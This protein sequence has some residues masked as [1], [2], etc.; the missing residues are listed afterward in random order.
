MKEKYVEIK[1]SIKCDQILGANFVSII[2]RCDH[3][4]YRNLR[5]HGMTMREPDYI[6]KSDVA[7]QEGRNAQGAL[8]SGEPWRVGTIRQDPQHMTAQLIDNSM[9]MPIAAEP[10]GF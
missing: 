6:I 10:V 3:Y 8:K 9:T 1:K 5:E 4:L 7:K 2:A